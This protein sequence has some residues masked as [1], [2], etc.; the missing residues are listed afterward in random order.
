[1]NIKADVKDSVRVA[2]LAF[3]ES[4]AINSD[5]A[6]VQDVDVPA[7]QQATSWILDTAGTTGTLTMGTGH[8]LQTGAVHDLFWNETV[9]G[10]TVRKGRRAVVLGTV[11]GDSVPITSSGA[12][13]AL[14]TEATGL[15]ITVGTR[16]ELDTTVAGDTLQ[17]IVIASK[18][19]FSFSLTTVSLVEEFGRSPCAGC[20]WKWYNGNGEPNPV[21]GDDITNVIVSQGATEVATVQVALTYQN[22]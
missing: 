6:I 7:A 1:M 12:G 10:A 5:A 17:L 4:V 21:A 8:T 9:N 3:S 14:P 20:I 18:K 2:G 13:D 16:V 22:A 19:V 11:T 15:I